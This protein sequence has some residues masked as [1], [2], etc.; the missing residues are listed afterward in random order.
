MWPDPIFAQGR[1]RLQCKRPQA[2][3]LQA[4]MPLTKIGSGDA[5]LGSDNGDVDNR[6]PT[7]Y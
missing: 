1:Y 3:I 6:G 4:T 7:V 5:R 2:F